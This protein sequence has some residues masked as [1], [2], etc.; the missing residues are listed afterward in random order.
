LGGSHSAKTFQRKSVHKWNPNIDEVTLVNYKGLIAMN[1]SSSDPT[2]ALILDL[3][4]KFGLIAKGDIRLWV[5]A[6]GT[7]EKIGA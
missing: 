1:E 4:A 5:E 7:D 3:C 2:R 6:E